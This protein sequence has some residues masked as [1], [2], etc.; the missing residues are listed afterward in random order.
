MTNKLNKKVLVV[1]DE[2]ALLKALEEKF[3]LEGFE[4]L[5]ARNGG[6]GRPPGHDSS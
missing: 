3:A 4:V 5:K 1:E 2:I 6:I